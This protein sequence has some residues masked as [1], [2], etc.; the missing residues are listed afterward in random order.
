MIHLEDDAASRATSSFDT[1]KDYLPGSDS[2]ENNGLLV[3][4]QVA[5]A[6]IAS[7]FFGQIPPII[8][9][10]FFHYGKTLTS[11]VPPPNNM[12]VFW[13]TFLLDKDSEHSFILRETANLFPNYR[14]SFKSDIVEYADFL[15]SPTYPRDIWGQIAMWRM[16]VIED[17]EIPVPPPVSDPKVVEHF[18][19][20][21]PLAHSYFS[22]CRKIDG[23]IGYRRMRS[24][25]KKLIRPTAENLPQA[26]LS[27]FGIVV[28][29]EWSGCSCINHVE[30]GAC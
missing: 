27:E 8:N 12:E 9:V 1:V 4:A 17:V 5:A 30:A 6:P 14:P 28:S 22:T 2:D 7:T 10:A 24:F 3:P 11:V 20:V 25:M 13:V 19:S 18:K 26:Q 23:V 29:G 16:R 15:V 21:G